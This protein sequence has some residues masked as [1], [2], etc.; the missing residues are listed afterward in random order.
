[1]I[2]TSRGECTGSLARIWASPLA[3]PTCTAVTLTVSG[4]MSLTCPTA[5]IGSRCVVVRKFYTLHTASA[6]LTAA[7]PILFCFQHLFACFHFAKHQ[8]ERPQM[9]HRQV[10]DLLLHLIRQSNHPMWIER[11]NCCPMSRLDHAENKS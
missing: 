9:T 8:L 6:R 2:P 1:M 4:S 10:H 3:A 11:L 7:P 5:N